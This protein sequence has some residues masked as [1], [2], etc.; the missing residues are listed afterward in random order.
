MAAASAIDLPF[1]DGTFDVVT[2]NFVVSHFTKY[3][4]ALFD[5]IRVLKPGGRLGMSSWADNNTDDLQKTWF[6][7]VEAAVGQLLLRDIHAQAV[8]WGERFA[9]RAALEEALMD[10]GLRQ[11]RTERREYRFTYALDEYVEG[12][13]TWSTGRFLRSMLGPAGW[14]S[15]RT[16]AREVFE[17]RFSDPVN[18]FRQVWLAVGRKP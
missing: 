13:G 8:P 16:R 6:G 9:D 15:F 12:L 4:T 14:E 11:I 2:A 1:R 10:A 17:E 18:D 3:K 7:L 5:M